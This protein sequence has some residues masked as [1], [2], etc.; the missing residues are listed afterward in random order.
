M[1]NY[2]ILS[3]CGESAAIADVCGSEQGSKD[4]NEE[5]EGQ[6]SMKQEADAHWAEMWGG[7]QAGP[8]NTECLADGTSHT[9]PT[10]NT[11]V[12]KPEPLPPVPRAVQ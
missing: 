6:N 5:K 2:Y 1:Q 4:G 9:R 8:F 12:D 3:V 7:I 11:C 10:G